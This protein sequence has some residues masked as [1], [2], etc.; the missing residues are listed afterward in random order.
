MFDLIII[1]G[2][3]AVLFLNLYLDQVL[4]YRTTKKSKSTNPDKSILFLNPFS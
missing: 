1:S 4:N 2:N 3:N